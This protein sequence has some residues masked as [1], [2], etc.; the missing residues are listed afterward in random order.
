METTMNCAASVITI[1]A[2]AAAAAAA[3]NNNS[4]KNNNN[5]ITTYLYCEG[6]MYS[7]LPFV[8]QD[9]KVAE[10]GRQST[11]LRNITTQKSPTRSGLDYVHWHNKQLDLMERFYTF[12]KMIQTCIGLHIMGVILICRLRVFCVA[13][14]SCR[15]Y[16]QVNCLH[17]KLWSC[18][19]SLSALAKKIHWT[20]DDIDVAK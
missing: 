12:G 13:D 2:A 3:G 16:I 14:F 11:S 9:C 17:F 5:A 7:V 1:A 19:S 8:A 10:K 6:T 18:S 4:N 20:C 15:G